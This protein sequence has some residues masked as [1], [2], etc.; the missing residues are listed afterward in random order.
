MTPST[1]VPRISSARSCDIEDLTIMAQVVRPTLARSI[2]L[3]VIATMF[4]VALDAVAKGLMGVLSPELVVWG[5]YAGSL[6]IVLVIML[7]VGVGATVRTQYPMLQ[8]AR[9]V[10]LVGATA[11]MF[12]ALRTLPVAMSYAISYVSPLMVLI[13]AAIVLGERI[14]R[15]Q[16][17]GTA[18][19]FAGV[20]VIIRPGF[21]PW[22]TTLLLPLASAAFYAAYQILTRRVGAADGAMTS[23][24][25]V[26]L[27][28]TVVTSMT[29]PWSYE[30]MAASTWLLLGL[31]GALGTAG[32]FFLI[33]A[34][35][36]APASLLS[37]FVYLQIVW[38]GLIDAF[39]FKTLLDPVTVLG[40]AIVIGSG[41]LILK[42]IR[43]APT[44]NTPQ[45]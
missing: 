14:T 42:S 27:G 44:A 21:V 6:L 15:R 40:A 3:F 9:G 20:L 28:G 25:Y 10:V 17:L 23:L 5:R 2:A 11:C 12:L 1:S 39:V 8:L 35:T 26:T 38:A 43:S 19:G 4:L 33:W 32:H 41:L 31:L 16:A 29:L 24:F 34:Y 36:G 30:P 18:L 37:P 7:G 22:E 13:M 45:T